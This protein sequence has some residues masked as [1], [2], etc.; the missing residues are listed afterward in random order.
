MTRRLV[1]LY[2]TIVVGP[3]LVAAL[4]FALRD[5]LREHEQHQPEGNGHAHAE[6]LSDTVEEA[7]AS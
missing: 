2:L 5:R 6:R 3:W 1:A 7:R 4:L